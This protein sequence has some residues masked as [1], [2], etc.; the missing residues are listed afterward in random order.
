MRRKIVGQGFLSGG[1]EEKAKR[2]IDTSGMREL[3]TY[4][5]YAPY[6]YTRVCAYMYVAACMHRAF[7][8]SREPA[9]ND[10]HITK[11]NIIM[12]LIFNGMNPLL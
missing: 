12:K 5:S 10:Q 1:K 2:L 7:V 4:I 11:G 9:G 3:C 8:L 6:K